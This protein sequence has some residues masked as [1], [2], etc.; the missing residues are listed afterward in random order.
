MLEKKKKFSAP[1]C[2]SLTQLKQV[3][4]LK[5]MSGEMAEFRLQKLT[6]AFGA[7][8]TVFNGLLEDAAKANFEACK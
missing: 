3:S 7:E 4:N 2:F 1:S 8:A 6:A 5:T